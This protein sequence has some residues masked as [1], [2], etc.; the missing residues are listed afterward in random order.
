MTLFDR[1]DAIGGQ[2]NLARQVPGK[3]EFH[4]LVHWFETMVAKSRITVKLGTETTAD[5]LSAL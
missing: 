4:G 1:A 2:L 3:E 5:A